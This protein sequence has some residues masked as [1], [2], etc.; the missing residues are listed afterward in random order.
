MTILNCNIPTIELLNGIADALLYYCTFVPDELFVDKLMHYLH[1][2]NLIP[3]YFKTLLNYR[4][5]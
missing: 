2:S 3:L 1:V 5:I 4:S